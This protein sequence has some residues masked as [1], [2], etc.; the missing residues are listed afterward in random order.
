[1]RFGLLHS[2]P[3]L[4]LTLAASVPAQ[5][6]RHYGGDAGG[7]RYSPLKQ[8]TRDNV[9]RLQVAWTY[10][11][12]DFSDPKTWPVPTAFEATPLVVDGVLYVTTPFCRLIAIEAETGREIWTFDPRIDRERPYYLLVNR[13][14]AY[15]TDGKRKRLYYGTLDGRLWAIDAG[16]GRPVE[17][18]GERGSVDLKEGVAEASP[19]RLYSLTSPPA[20][21]KDLVICGSAT[22]DGEPRAPLGDVRAFDAHTGKLVWT[23][24]VVPRKGEPGNEAWEGESWKQRG[25]ANAWSMLSVDEERGIVYLPLT[26]P[27]FDFYGGDRPGVNLYGDSLVALDAATGRRLWHFQTVHHNIWDYDLP[28]QP[29]LATVRRGGASVPAVVQVTKTGFTFVFDRVTGAPL[30]EIEERAVP[31]SEVPGEQA[32]PTQPFP[33]RPRPFAR[34]S[35]TR[36]ELTDVTPESRAYCA[37]LVEGAVFGSLFT[38]IGLKPTVLFPGTNGGAN[39]GG[40][41]FD[42]ETRTLFVNSM[43]VGMMYRMVK[44]PEGS[45]VPYRQQGSGTQH[46][47]FWDKNRYPC[48]K[49][50]WGHLTAIDLDSG[51]FR[52]RS[53]LGVIDELVAKGLPPTGTSNIGGSI[54]T[55]GGLVFIGATNDKR[56]RAFDKETGKELWVA[57]LPTSA[58]AAPATFLGQ[59]T[60]KQFVVIAAGGGN[61]YNDDYSDALVAFSLP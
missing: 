19:D 50:P 8:I 56:F 38:P 47:R 55:A 4:V 39:W 23:F 14:A 61:K 60:G 5:E 30:F 17:G 34:Q 16:T 2:I 22:S 32:W 28:A 31:T 52:W 9:T 40:A 20:I 59:N 6:W 21:Y 58:H 46:S 36:E 25:G 48:Q 51:E 15:W 18:F 7:S 37:K 35:M 10:R 45:D 24:H 49:P 13:G 33:V 44:R 43:D 41:S 53:V 57:R 42:P 1:V 29:V 12:G 54:V 27:S 26:S 3:V 11:T